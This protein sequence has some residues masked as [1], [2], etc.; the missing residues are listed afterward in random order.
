MA[1]GSNG[2]RKTTD[3]RTAERLDLRRNQIF[4]AAARVFTLKGFHNATVQDV[5]DEAGLGK[6]TIYEYVSS[7]KELLFLV[8]EEGQKMV[9]SAV[10]DASVRKAPA[11]RRLRAMM[12]TMLSI[13]DERLKAAR[14]IITEVEGLPPEDFERLHKKK[15]EFINIF[16]DVYDEGIAAGDFRSVNSFIFTELM[17][18]CCMEWTKSDT[19]VQ[20]GGGIEAYEE[21]LSGMFI[22][23]ILARK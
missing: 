19:L 13:M 15:S 23:S 5:A 16:K 9:L 2:T 17:L 1:T 3:E 12:H 4:E 20:H 8:I 21:L 14:A 6:G 11:A 7:K 22:E 18:V 10:E